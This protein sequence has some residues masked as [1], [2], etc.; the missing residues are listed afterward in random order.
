M[1]GVC[2]TYAIDP[3]RMTSVLG[4]ATGISSMIP[5]MRLDFPAPTGPQHA[6]TSPFR[7]EKSKTD[8]VNAEESLSSAGVTR[9][10]SEE[11]DWEP[12]AKEACRKVRGDST[13]MDFSPSEARVLS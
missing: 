5:F 8:T 3:L 1:N 9:S 2:G 7:M 13:S 11:F 6:M 12:T 10:F 4:E